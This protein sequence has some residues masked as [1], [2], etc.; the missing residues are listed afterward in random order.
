MAPQQPSLDR[1][2]VN[3][4]HDPAAG[5]GARRTYIR[6]AVMKSYHERRNQ[7][8][9]AS[10]LEAEV[11]E[12]RAG[13]RLALMASID[14]QMAPQSSALIPKFILF[15]RKQFSEPPMLH[16]SCFIL[17]YLCGQVSKASRDLSFVG[18]I[19]NTF[20]SHE[21]QGGSD[22]MAMNLNSLKTS[23][24][25]WQA[26]GT[27]S[28]DSISVT[29]DNESLWELIHQHQEWIYSK[30]TTFNQWELLS[31][32]QATT[33][34]LLLRVKQGSNSA[35]FPNGDIALLFTLGAIF[36][37]LHSTAL[38]DSR[39]RQDWR[40]W[41]F[42]ESFMRIACIYFTL[43]AVV[44]THFGLPCHNPK[45]WS[46]HS[47]PVPA[48]KASWAAANASDWASAL[49]P[50]KELTWKDL[51]SAA[52]LN[53]SP[54]DLWRESSDELGMVVMMTMTLISQQPNYSMPSPPE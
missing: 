24:N 50:E 18:F 5:R 29:A 48:T 36:R 13:R 20:S 40:Q 47:L 21:P 12:N 41:V 4:T 15:E 42:F 19:H 22:H 11:A 32:A 2:F 25:L 30:I 6:R 45:D 10:K 26:Y 46:F 54:V 16:M 23:L 28:N 8:K 52:S 53:D 49:P 51:T 3:M 7:K 44:S 37:H 39:P 38:L 9:R 27:P 14:R 34:Y 17:R 31:A 1:T 35:A 33:I 43:S